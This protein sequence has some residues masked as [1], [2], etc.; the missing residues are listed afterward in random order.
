M[1]TL[2]S[3]TWL[4]TLG[5]A[6]CSCKKGEDKADDGKADGKAASKDTKGEADA[7]GSDEG[8]A[9]L[10][11]AEGDDNVDG[12]IPPEA[13]MVLFSIEGALMPLACFD[14]AS[15]AV[16]SGKACLAMVKE[17]EAVRLDA[18]FSNARN[19][20]AGGPVV[21]Q[22]LAGAGKEVAIGV[23]GLSDVNYKFA[24]WPPAGV[25]AVKLVKD[26]TMGGS[27]LS[28]DD[29]TK[30]KLLAAIQKNK[31][32]AKGE[33]ELHQ[34]AEVDL[35]GN[36][37]K[38]VFYSVF[39]KNPKMSEQYLWSGIFVATDGKTDALSL[40]E[41]SKSLK[42][43]FEL[44]ATVDMDGKDAREV[45]LRLVWAEGGGD[46]LYQKKGGAF[47]PLGQWTC[48]AAR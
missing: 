24:T 48:G 25:R 37:T 19:K 31:A 32:S 42:D 12:P 18:G 36:P 22:C 11:V 44:R 33:V 3:C 47:E 35:D 20:S 17:G 28:V 8:E 9:S 46:R 34:V 13:S 26:D 40:V 5:L 23:E 14:K 10:V 16:K 15:G 27:A 38:E 29:D 30:A 7:A 43:I 2:R 21:P 39:I 41:K 6:L 45:W 1:P 4:L